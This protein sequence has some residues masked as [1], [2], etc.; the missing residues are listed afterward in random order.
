[1]KQL[2]KYI[3]KKYFSTFLLSI[4]LLIIVVV[5]FDVSE[6]IDDFISG[7]APMREIIFDYYF[8]FIPYFLN[9]FLYLFVFI[10]VIFFTTK[11]AQNS[12]IIAILSSG[13]SYWRFLRPYLVSS[14]ILLVVAMV[15][16]N[17]IIPKT[18]IR[19]TEFDKT[20]IH[21]SSKHTYGRN[22]HVQVS[23]GVFAYVRSFDSKKGSG[24]DFSLENINLEDGMTYK[25]RAKEVSYD[26]DSCVWHLVDYESR[27]VCENG[28]ILSSGKSMDTVM[29]L[30]P[31][32]FVFASYDIKTMDFFELKR[33]I[34]DEKIK[35]VR[36]VTDL[37]VEQHSRIAGAF[38]TI[39]LT[40]LGVGLSSRKK[41]SG[42]GLNLG[43]GIALTFAYILFQQITK[44]FATNSG[45]APWL[46]AWIPN[47][48][49]AAI[50]AVVL[51][52]AAE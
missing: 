6:K 32:D 3:I 24:S 25:L 27:R 2:D 29:T 20:Y 38:A 39:I 47:F 36:L 41:R 34:E 7:N 10:S 22:I 5:V 51:Y 26:F 9:L 45:L 52:K 33:F 14:V 21:N 1:M 17:F 43:V 50:T 16:S 18:N 48:V 11:I 19:L 28:E 13:V 49:Y 31:K 23:P 12:E 40:F 30:K 4:S 37:E 44:V 46:A 35:G 15:L 42:M 8:N